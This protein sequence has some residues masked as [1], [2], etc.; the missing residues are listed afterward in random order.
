MKESGVEIS[1][2]YA[3]ALKSSIGNALIAGLAVGVWVSSLRDG[4]YVGGIWLVS[5]VAFD[6]GFIWFSN[7]SKS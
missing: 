6:T 1:Q 7:R 4:L 2:Q 5:G 3:E